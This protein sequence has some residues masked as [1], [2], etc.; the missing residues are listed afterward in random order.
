MHRSPANGCQSAQLRAKRDTSSP[1]TMPALPRLTSVTSFW[2]PS[3][4]AVEAGFCKS[5]ERGL[6]GFCLTA[7]PGN[8]GA[9]YGFA[10]MG[11]VQRGGQAEYLRVP[12][13][14][15]NCL[16]LPPEARAPRSPRL[17][18]HPAFQRRA[19]PLVYSTRV[20]IGFRIVPA[21]TGSV[22]LRLGFCARPNYLSR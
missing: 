20:P 13:G 15:F 18:S 16:V 12:Y 11:P 3:R 8:A 6:T 2:K 14:D 5:C 19:M 21:L 7:N 9:A 22:S 17:E 10:G 4:S 1:I